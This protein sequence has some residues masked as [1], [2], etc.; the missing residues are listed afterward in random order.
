MARRELTDAQDALLEPVLP[1]NVRRGRPWVDHRNM[2]NGLVW[3]L[4]A[5]ARWPD[6]SERDG[7]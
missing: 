4:N 3:K 7:P 1:A 5:G 6:I 2:L